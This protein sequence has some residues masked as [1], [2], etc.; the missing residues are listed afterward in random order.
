MQA[1]EATYGGFVTIIKY[2]IPA[3]A[4]IAAVVI[5]LIS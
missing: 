1:A 4:I 5:K 2:A 3:I